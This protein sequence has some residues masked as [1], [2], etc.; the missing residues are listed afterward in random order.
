[1]AAGEYAGALK[2]LVNAHKEH[3]ALAL[4]RPLGEVLAAVVGAFGV[5]TGPSPGGVVLVPVP[6]R[7][8]AVR[9]RGHDPVLRTARVAAT[10][11]R[12]TGTDA[13]VA[14][15]LVPAVRLEDQAGLDAGQR[16]ANL[17]GAL[18]SRLRA[19]GASPPVLV[20]DDVITTGATAREAQRALTDAGFQVA[21]IATVAATRRRTSRA[22]I[23]GVGQE[24]D[25]SLSHSSGGD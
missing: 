22:R 2:A 6:S 4:A 23:P 19:A 12:R 25:P 14:R 7:P 18:R 10:R 11:L 3:Q 8:E 20:V 9:R 16:A 24:T 15:L 17:G 5:D 13:R 1:M 21:G